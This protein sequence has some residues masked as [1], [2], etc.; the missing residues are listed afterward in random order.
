MKEWDLENEL[1]S[2]KEPG[3]QRHSTEL[4]FYPQDIRKGVEGFEQEGDIYG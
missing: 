2:Q 4:W 3:L 1:E